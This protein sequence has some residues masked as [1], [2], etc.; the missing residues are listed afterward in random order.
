MTG[1]LCG[2]NGRFYRA[3][4]ISYRLLFIWY[5]KRRNITSLTSLRAANYENH[6]VSMVQ[7]HEGKVWKAL[8]CYGVKAEGISISVI[9]L[10][11]K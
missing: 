7:N 4:L 3:R 2:G 9:P 5:E 10:W 8:G 1:G 6:G 11:A